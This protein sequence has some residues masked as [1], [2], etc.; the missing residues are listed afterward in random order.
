MCFGV[1]LGG[2]FFKPVPRGV[3]VFF[4]VGDF[5]EAV[6]GFGASL[7]RGLFVPVLCLRGIAGDA[8]PVAVHQREVVL[9]A[10]V[11]LCGGFVI[12]RGGCRGIGG[13]AF[14]FFVQDAEAVLCGGIACVGKCLHRREVARVNGGDGFFPGGLFGGV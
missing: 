8:P 13:Y 2:G 14:A 7:C 12:P 4:A 11:A 10:G 5:A 9:R 6:L 3:V 1:L